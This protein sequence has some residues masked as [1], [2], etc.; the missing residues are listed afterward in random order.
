MTTPEIAQFR[1]D[2]SSLTDKTDG[3]SGMTTSRP[4][5]RVFDYLPVGLFGSVLGLTG[6]SVLWRLAHQSYGMPIWVSDSIAVCAVVVFLLLSICYSLKCITAFDAV[7]S[8][9]C[10]PITRSLFATII[11]S[12][13]LLPV[14]IAPVSI[15]IARVS[16]CVGAVAM[17][18]FAWFVL[19]RWMSDTQQIAHATPAWILPVV[20]LID[21]P[22]A[23]PSLAFSAP[24]ALIALSLAVGLFFA[25]VL[26]TVIFSRLLFQPQMPVGLQPTLLILSSPFALGFM[27]YVTT[28][29]PI[30][31]FARALYMLT[32]FLL[33][34]LV[35]RLRHFVLCCPFRVAWWSVSFPVAAA[36]I[37]SMV[38]AAEEPGTVADGIAIT[39]LACSTALIMGLLCRTLT[40]ITR[41]QLRA[42]S[43]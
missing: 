10:D 38:Y 9:F 17:L 43:R 4:P 12:L 16:W 34:I 7:R 32:L 6:H 27:I 28:I 30:D 13:L 15:P 18:L 19:N 8:E 42:L 36:A 20:G 26:F 22:L 1:C 2:A 33:T 41:G 31:L 29:G 39:M 21:I 35:G 23:I 3:R 40:G 11:V 5:L 24:P 37:A 25:V 14:V